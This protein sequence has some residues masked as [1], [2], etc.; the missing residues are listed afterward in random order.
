MLAMPENVSVALLTV[1]L[2]EPTLLE[3]DT[4]NAPPLRTVGPL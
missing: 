4:V 1:T 3:L 2:P